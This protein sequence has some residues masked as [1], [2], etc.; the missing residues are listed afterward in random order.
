MLRWVHQTGSFLS[1]RLELP[2]PTDAF[3]LQMKVDVYIRPT[4]SGVELTV[5]TRAHT[6]FVCGLNGIPPCTQGPCPREDREILSLPCFELH[7][8]LTVEAS[9]A[10]R[11]KQA[12]L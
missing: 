3:C 11:H 8:T 6:C 12:S 1:T 5:S 2:F 4:S 10:I 9:G 7:D